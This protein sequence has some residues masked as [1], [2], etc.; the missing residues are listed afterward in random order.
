MTLGLAPLASAPVAALWRPDIAAPDPGTV[1]VGQGAVDPVWAI[2]LQGAAAGPPVPAP[3]GMVAALPVAAFALPP[4]TDVGIPTLRYSDR[5]WIGEP[6]DPDAPNERWPGRLIEAPAL[7]RTIPIYPGGARRAEVSGG[8]IFLAN[9]D[10]GLDA[11]TTDWRLAGRT[12]EILRG[13]YRSPVRAARSEF[14]TIGTFRIA[15]LAQG[16]GRLRLPLASAAAELTMPV[17]ATYGGTGGADGTEAMTGQDKPVRYGIHRNASGVLVHPGLLAYQ[18][19]D[20]RISAVLAVRGRGGA[21]SFAGDYGSW[22]S[23][24]AAVPAAGTYITCLALGFIRLGSTTSSLTVDFRGAAPDGWG[25]LNTAASIA[26]HLLRVPGGITPERAQATSFYDWP[27]GEVRLDAT[28][29]TVAGAL[30]ALAGGV[31]GWWGADTAGRFR[32]SALVPPELGGPSILLE[33]WM[34]SSPP[35]EVEAAQAPWWRVRVAYQVLGTVQTGEDLAGSVSDVNRALYGQPYQVDTAYDPDVQSAFPGATDGPLVESAFDDA[36]DAG[37]YST[38]LMELFGAARR[39]W[40][41]SIRADQAWR[42]WS[43]MEPGQLVRLT[44]PGIAALRDG[45]TLVLRGVS[46]RGDRLTLDLWG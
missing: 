2:A 27:A 45:K 13:P 19:N 12:L 41:V 4:S 16:T 36:A 22:G 44:W 37:A 14:A 34:L 39:A 32:G 42:F 35:Q 24:A 20:G 30:D 40:Q 15:R 25:Y 17:S 6:T 21:Y 18:M 10:G 31:G 46:A 38:R 29:M 7:E 8:E 9:G 43:V 28:G 26:E 33:P 3:F 5:G 11:L 1:R 23:F